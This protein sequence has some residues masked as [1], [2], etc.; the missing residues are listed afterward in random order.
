MPVAFEGIW[1]PIADNHHPHNPINDQLADGIQA[2]INPHETIPGKAGGNRK[3]SIQFPIANNY[4]SHNPIND[5]PAD[6]IQPIIETSSGKPFGNRQPSIHPGYWSPIGSQA[7]SALVDGYTQLVTDRVR[8]GW[9][10][11]LVA[12][13]R[14]FL[15]VLGALKVHIFSAIRPYPV[16]SRP[17]M[18]PNP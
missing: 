13:D 3:P 18:T 4:H 6:N 14:I 5:Q 12:F 16:W 10:C 11:H 15:R 7:K 2:T 17:I 9:S 8:A 1:L